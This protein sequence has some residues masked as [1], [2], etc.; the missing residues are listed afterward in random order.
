MGK[1]QTGVL[2][3][4]RSTSLI[5]LEKQIRWAPKTLILHH[6]EIGTICTDCT[7]TPKIHDKSA[8]Y[9]QFTFA[10]LEDIAKALMHEARTMRIDSLWN[11]HGVVQYP[12]GFAAERF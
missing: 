1:G 3:H 9:H 6:H 2:H 7:I 11:G 5:V 4:N 10:E 8:E 12:G